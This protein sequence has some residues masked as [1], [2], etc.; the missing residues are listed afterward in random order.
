MK[1]L[2]KYCLLRRNLLHS[3]STTLAITLLTLLVCIPVL[4]HEQ[5][6]A[7][8]TINIYDILNLNYIGSLWW[9]SSQVR[10]S[11]DGKWVV[12]QLRK[13]LLD[14]NSYVFDLWLIGSSGKINPKQLTHNKPN[15]SM[16]AFLT[17]LWSP[18]SKTIAYFVSDEKGKG[19]ALIQ[20]DN[21]EER[22]LK[23]SE[24]MRAGFDRRIRGTISEFKWS[25][26]GRYIAFTAAS[27]KEKD[28]QQIRGIGVDVTWNPRRRIPPS[29]ALL[30][31]VEVSTGIILSITDESLN[32]H[33]FNWS[34]DGKR[35]AFSASD[36]LSW[37]TAMKTDMY[38]VDV[39]TRKV[40]SLLK[41]PGPDNN[42][43][44]SPDGKWIAFNSQKGKLDWQQRTTIGVLS[45]SGGKPFYPADD[46]WQKSGV[47]PGGLRWSVDSKKIY[48]RAAYHM[49]RR[50][51]RVTLNDGKTVQ[52]TPDDNQCYSQFSFSRDNKVLAFTMESIT[53][54]PDIYMSLLSP[55][56]PRRITQANPQLD[57]GAR[58]QIEVLKWRS[59]DGKWDIPGVLI[60]PPDYQPGK[61][62][63]LLI[64]LQGGPGMVHMRY[65]L[66]PQYPIQAFAAKGY[67]VL[68]P[69]TRG[70]WGYGMPFYNAIR[71][72]KDRGPGPFQDMMAGVDLLIEMGMADPDRLGIMGFSYGGYLTAFAITQT[73]RFKAA[74]IGEGL[75]NVPY[76]AFHAGG[77]PSRVDFQRDFSGWDPPYD[78]AELKEM[79]RQSPIHNVQNVKTPTLLEYGS[80]SM[81]PEYGRTFFQGLWHFKVPSEFIVYHRTGHG[82]NE[83]LL[84]EDSM[85]RN[86][87]WFDYWVLGKATRKM[88]EKYGQK[89][90]NN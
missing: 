19:L 81:A 73:D 84:L 83:P 20:I 18:D 29:P 47:S 27:G 3:Y 21:L 22:R 59:K 68:A 86:L 31:I 25:P 70:R 55:F 14:Q 16:V 49:T 85:K 53:E 45:F 32:V 30:Y 10:I 64:F 26:D 15:T 39:E 24:K 50:L 2:V 37:Y 61:K 76:N 82:I 35:I 72:N 46:F 28:A 54:P 69:N 77:D 42:P 63:P 6:S 90:K 36:K 4:S 62:Y 48:F 11:P 89:H 79:M 41:Q 52:I 60:K 71:D 9:G 57:N 17:P 65:D 5:S 23:L 13:T 8:R 12:Y 34:P 51:F 40:R 33:T 78:P 67:L 88:K 1:S 58:S 43:V 87:E 56:K 38:V 74:S 44:W 7:K 80:E 66:T 75:T